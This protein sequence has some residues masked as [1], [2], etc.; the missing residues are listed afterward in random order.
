MGVIAQCIFIIIERGDYVLGGLF[1]EETAKKYSIVC[2][3][4]GELNL[5]SK[6]L[7]YYDKDWKC[8]FFPNY[9]TIARGNV[10]NLIKVLQNDLGIDAVGS[11][12]YLY[13]C[14][15]YKY[16][17]ESKEVLPY[18]HTLYLCKLKEFPDVQDNY[19]WLTVSEM[20]NDE[21]IR[22]VNADVVAMLQMGLN[23]YKRV[24]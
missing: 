14:V 18:D 22:K 8:W 1:K 2:I 7:V 16:S 19:K 3:T 17:E 20:L 11:L 24:N 12:K 9:K 21:R 15:H 23:N 10:A 5:D 4:Y 13:R 6:F